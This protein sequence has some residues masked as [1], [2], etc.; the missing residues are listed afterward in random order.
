VR[1]TG[2]PGQR[3]TVTFS[4]APSRA[5]KAGL[6]VTFACLAGLLA[7]LIAVF[8]RGRRARHA[9]GLSGRS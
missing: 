7:L 1:V 4:T 5:L 3:Q 9:A 2:P 6:I 8:V